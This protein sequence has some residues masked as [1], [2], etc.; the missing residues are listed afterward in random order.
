MYFRSML[1]THKLI[2]LLVNSPM[3]DIYILNSSNLIQVNQNG[4]KRKRAYM[5]AGE[6]GVGYVHSG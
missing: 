6:K 3:P 5:C 2:T 4:K 1:L